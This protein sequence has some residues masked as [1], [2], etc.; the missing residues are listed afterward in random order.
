M[1]TFYDNAVVVVGH[2]KCG[3]VKACYDVATHSAPAPEGPLGRWLTPLVE[4]AGQVHKTNV[5]EHEA[6]EKI[7]QANVRA[8]VC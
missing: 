4:L 7:T 1:L 3:G 6:I 8:Q 2:S 5:M